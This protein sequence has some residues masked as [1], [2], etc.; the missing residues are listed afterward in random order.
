MFDGRIGNSTLVEHTIKAGDNPIRQRPRRVPPHF[1]AEVKKE[2]Q[3]LLDKGIWEEC[4]G[5]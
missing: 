4:N 3:D 1:E 2:I 5:A